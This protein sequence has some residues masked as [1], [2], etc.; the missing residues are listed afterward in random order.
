MARRALNKRIWIGAVLV[1]LLAIS[2]SLRA[3]VVVQN[4]TKLRITV[5]GKKSD[6]R[7]SIAGADVLLRSN[8]GGFEANP[9]TDSKGIANVSEV[10]YG[11]VLIQVTAAGWETFGQF[12]DLNRKELTIPVELEPS[13]QPTPTPKP[14]ETPSTE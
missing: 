11:K 5:S 13:Q 9:S 12:Y 2:A 4:K 6:K 7:I 14:T 10:P 3:S 1:V 8:D